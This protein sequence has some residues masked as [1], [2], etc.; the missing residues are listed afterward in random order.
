MHRRTFDV[1]HVEACVAGDGHTAPG[2]AGT[3]NYDALLVLHHNTFIVVA[4][5]DHNRARAPGSVD[6]CLDRP[7]LSRDE[8]YVGGP[9]YLAHVAMLRLIIIT[10][11]SPGVSPVTECRRLARVKSLHRTC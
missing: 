10:R 4:R 6:G 9:N 1:K 2:Q 5:F 8:Q 7:K 3:H 11:L